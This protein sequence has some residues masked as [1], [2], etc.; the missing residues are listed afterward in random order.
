LIVTITY[1]N[2][3]LQPRTVFKKFRKISCAGLAIAGRYQ[4]RNHHAAWA[5]G[6]DGLGWVG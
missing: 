3:P 6:T 4:G 5:I 1:N 2:H